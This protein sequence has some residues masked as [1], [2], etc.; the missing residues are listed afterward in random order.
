MNQVA[1]IVHVDNEQVRV[2]EWLLAPGAATGWHRHGF[3]YVIT[4]VTAG[5]VEIVGPDHE[6]T[7]F[8]ME[9]GKSYYREAGVE[10]DVVNGPEGE[11]V[12]I[13]VEIKSLPG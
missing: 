9:P 7:P 2:I 1:S 3:A 10:N 13:E 8:A 11:L 6:S 5:Q 12:F 4:P